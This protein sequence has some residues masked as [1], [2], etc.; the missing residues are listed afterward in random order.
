MKLYKTSNFTIFILVCQKSWSS[1][2][3]VLLTLSAEQTT[4]LAFWHDKVSWSNINPAGQD[5]LS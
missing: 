5:S 3:Y 1:I 4:P 2:T